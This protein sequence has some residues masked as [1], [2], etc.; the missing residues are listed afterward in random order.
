[1]FAHERLQAVRALIFDYVRSPSLRHIRD[2]RSV[3]ALVQQILKS[4]DQEPTVWRKWQGR[5]EEVLRAAAL[6][7]VPD[8]ELQRFLNDLPGPALTLTDVAQRL[9][10]IHEEPYSRYPD[11]CL[12]DDCL[13]LFDLETA[14]GTELPA[15]IGAL[16]EYVEEETQ[17]RRLAEEAGYRQRQAEE[18]ERLEHR[19]LAGAD[20]KWTPINGSKALFTRK[21]GRAYRLSP[22]RDKRW[23]LFRIADVEDTGVHLGA[24]AARTD[25]NRALAKLAYAPEPRW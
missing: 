19:F 14:Q 18:R 5:R 25:A 9:R 3:D 4:V 22:T 15:I 8:E 17:R 13:A 6:C 23:E 11:E 21:N 2:P 12:R 20:C 7:W 10:A 16:Q 24:Y 1:M